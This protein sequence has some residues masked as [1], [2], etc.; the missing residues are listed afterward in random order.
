MYAI[1]LT[2]FCIAYTW[3]TVKALKRSK[4]KRKI[5][6]SS[7]L[8]QRLFGIPLYSWLLVKLLPEKRMLVTVESP[9]PKKKALISAYHL[10]E[11]GLWMPTL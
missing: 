1:I 10:S 11:S 2:V 4:S 3:I 9:S 6:N 8:V 7:P 5:K